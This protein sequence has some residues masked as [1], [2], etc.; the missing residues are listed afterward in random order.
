MATNARI[1]Q[2]LSHLSLDAGS[3]N[4]PVSA[5]ATSGEPHPHSLIDMTGKV[6][7]VTGGSRGLG[8]FQ[9]R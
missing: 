2:L 3:T 1:S 7:V 5:N 4:S 6:I 8:E 9:S